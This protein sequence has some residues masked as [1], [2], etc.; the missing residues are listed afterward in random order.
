[1][2]GIILPDQM[3]IYDTGI[4]PRLSKILSKIPYYSISFTMCG[5]K[6]VTCV[7]LANKCWQA[8]KTICTIGARRK[9]R[10]VI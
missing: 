5:W 1:M 7:I 8:F 10:I 3:L 6:E 4:L 2:S 9:L